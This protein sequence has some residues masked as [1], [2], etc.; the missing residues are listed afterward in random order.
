MKIF[1]LRHEDRTQDATFFSPLTSTGLDNSMNLVKVLKKY[2]INKI[3]SSP[4]IR[5][6]QTITPYSKKYDVKI[7]LEYSLSEIQHPHIIPE[8]SHQ[9]RLPTY[10]AETFNYNAKYKSFLDP[11]QYKYPEDSKKVST[12]VRKFL[13]HLFNNKLM[14]DDNILL[15]THQ[16]VC[17][18]LL[19][20]STKELK[21][22]NI[23]SDYKY[24]KGALSLLFDKEEWL[25][26]PLNWENDN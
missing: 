13:N 6:L 26:E 4:F 17:N 21:E 7:N 18:E 8:N 23:S 24:P 3:Y 22:I 15:V 20:I 9:V 2:N 25:F 1:I 5:T 14:K 12:R 10:M 11:T 19:K 16:A